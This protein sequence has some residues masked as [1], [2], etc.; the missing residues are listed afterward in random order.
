MSEG[1]MLTTKSSL[2]NYGLP[3]PEYLGE[4]DAQGILS[5]KQ[6]QY[7]AVT[8]D[9]I[10][11]VVVDAETGLFRAKQAR[12]LK[13]SGPLMTRDS[14]G[15]YW[16]ALESGDVILPNS[17]VA[18]IAELF[19][20]AGGSVTQFSDITVAR[21]LAV[22]GVD[23]PVLR[24]VLTRKLP[25][26][27]LLEDSVRRFE[28]DQQIQAIARTADERLTRFKSIEDAFE[29]DCD[30]VTLRM[31][32]FFPEL[33]KTAAQA[34]WRDTSA[35]ERLHMHNQPGLPRSVAEQALMA[36]RDVRLA[37]ACEGIYLDSV[38]SLDSDRLALQMIGRLAAWPSTVRVE[39][40]QR[41]D[42]DVLSA[43][44]DARSATRHVLIRRQEG[45]VTQHSG[46]R[47]PFQ[48]KDLY[49]V[50]WGLLLPQQRQ[51]LGI[52]DAP[53]LRRLIRAQP[54]PSRQA[55][56]EWLGLGPLPSDV[57]RAT[58]Q[59]K[60]AGQLRGGGDPESPRSFEDRVRDLYPQL[61]DE[62]VSS[63]VAERLKSDPAG[64]LTR[65]EKEFATLR[66]EL[67]IW[68]ANG[69]SPHAQTSGPEGAPAA[70]GQRQAREQFSA[71]LQDIWQRKSVSKWDDGDDCF[72][73]YVDFPGELPKLFVRFEYVTELLLT[74]NEPGARLGAFLDSFPNLQYLGVVGIKVEE[75]PSG[76]FQMRQLRELTL[77]GCSLKLSES[78]A[79]GLSRIETLGRLNLANNPLTVAPY[80]GHMAGLTG[81]MLSN[82]NLSSVPAGI[83]KLRKL[84]V[85][86]LHNNNISD[87]GNELFDIPDTQNLFVGLLGNPL[88]DVSRQRIHQ[89]LENASLDRKVKIQSEDV[90]LE[91][92]SDSESSESGFSTGSDD[93]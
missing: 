13:P 37:R 79:E 2:V 58:A 62:E 43:I 92:D 19:R 61:S 52:S 88:S 48:V 86:A 15:R 5:L 56:S 23:V 14:E 49:S 1:L 82:A 90:V 72:S 68:N 11:Q 81:L 77:D 39:I 65:L 74:A 78:T 34:I 18:Q 64:V 7:V 69:A 22:T 51:L 28:L 87:I 84:G 75:F 59:H 16:L 36:L 66:H 20:R 26:P 27:F 41:V 60:Q 46:E 29:A 76:I 50:V 35:A 4:A 30:E 57:T 21:V 33:P 32:R 45:Y 47:L 67:A 6:R 44:G 85:M 91:S 8:D 93:D 9:I 3:A 63:F 17:S 89:Y 71:R 80:V 55:V 31:R 73:H 24:D 10:V 38:S 40:R 54:L 42:G 83:D 53:A 70:A 25:A 12:E